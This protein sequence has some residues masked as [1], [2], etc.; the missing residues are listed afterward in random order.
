MKVVVTVR[1]DEIDFG[2]SL[3]SSNCWRLCRTMTCVSVGFSFSTRQRQQQPILDL[4][5]SC[6]SL[7]H[8]AGLLLE[9][10]GVVCVCVARHHK[11]RETSGCRRFN[12]RYFSFLFDFGCF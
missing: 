4:N 8:T 5:G 1:L 12:F 9:E 11:Q 7:R 10:K 6:T 2:L 3:P